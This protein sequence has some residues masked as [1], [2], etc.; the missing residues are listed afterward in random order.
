MVRG[1]SGRMAR[2][3]SEAG[4]AR[5]KSWRGRPATTP[6]EAGGVAP[7]GVGSSRSLATLRWEGGGAKRFRWHGKQKT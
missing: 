4:T 5:G 2:A 1:M 3:H 6:R 7:G